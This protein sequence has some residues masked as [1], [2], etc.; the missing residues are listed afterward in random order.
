MTGTRKITAAL[1]SLCLVFSSFS[2][3]GCAQPEENTSLPDTRS[4][5]SSD[6]DTEESEEEDDE[7]ESSS[8]ADEENDSDEDEE[9]KE[10]D[11]SKDKAG[12]KNSGENADTKKIAFTLKNG[13]SWPEGNI[14]IYQLDGTVTNNQSDTIS[15]WKVTVP[16]NKD[17]DVKNSWGLTWELDGSTLIIKPDNNTGNI[18]PNGSINFGIQIA[19][20]EDISAKEAVFTARN[21][22]AS[23]GAQNGQNNNNNWNQN[24]NGNQNSNQN[25]GQTSSPNA[26]EVPAPST[27][28]WLS[29]EK[30]KIVDKNGKEVWLTGCNWFGYNTGTNI[31][32]G[33]WNADLNTS[34]NAIADHGFN[35]IRIPISTELVNQWE[36]GTYP[37]ANFN[38]ATNSYLVGMNSL[39]IFNYVIGQCRANGMKIMIDFH[40]A[41]TNAAGHNYPLWC[42][43]KISE[44]DY[45]R[46]LEWIAS[47][48][49]DDDTIIAI[50]LENEPHGKPDENPRAKWDDSKDSDNWKYIAEKAGLAVLNKNPNLL[51][52]VEGI[53]CYPIDTKKN[54]NYKSTDKKDYYFNWWGG[55]LRGVADHPVD[56]GKYNNKLVYSP[57]DY[58]PTVY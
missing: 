12:D 20:P 32:D 35:L 52:M 56:L 17:I 39:E 18:L 6:A 57:H 22:S 58:G 40:C 41:T 16:V 49:K 45:I 54:G 33:L 8:E 43:D 30:N 51:V 53:E 50:D 4:S 26:K 23:N 2:L 9:D 19:S 46:A 47:T 28:D 11:K 5:D 27:D 37:Q 36:D 38:Q 15:D 44:K 31:F 48:Y 42:D 21:T 34:V 3:T 25:G 55:N 24:N 10:K 29:V 7:E 14:N 13:N 1:L